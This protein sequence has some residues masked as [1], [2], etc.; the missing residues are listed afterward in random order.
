MLRP[1][2]LSIICAAL[3]ASC[4]ADGPITAWEEMFL[5]EKLM[6]SA[7]TVTIPAADGG[8]RP[9]VASERVLFQAV[10]READRQAPPRWLPI[11]LLIGGLLGAA[12]YGLARLGRRSRAARFGFGFL[13][14]LWTLVMGIGGL[15]L[16]ALWGL[17]NH[18]I[19]D[20]NENLLQFV[21]LALP[22]VVLLPAAT[23]GARWALRPARA[24]AIAVAVI[25]VL[26]LLL[27]ILPGLDQVNGEIIAL[28]LPVNVAVAL[29]L[30]ALRPADS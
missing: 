7:R 9:L 5:P 10:G 17:T 20:R 26:G 15:L 3:T 14:A 29:G 16:L 11:Y 2:L 28:V 19:A 6:E 12:I 23:A 13:G 27:Q 22:L 18:T 1:V 21:A 30:R 8:S 25:S 4:A 24:V